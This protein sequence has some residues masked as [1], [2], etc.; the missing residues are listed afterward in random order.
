[1]VAMTTTPPEGAPRRLRQLPEAVTYAR[2]Q[3][4]LKQV[5]L[6]RRVGISYQLMSDIER[7][8]RSATDETLNRL[9]EALNC[10]RII[11]EAKR[12]VT[13]G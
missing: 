11:L 5:E 10:P 3:A 1:M 7:G 2:E 6:A 4:G 12:E 9:A 13:T 8:Y